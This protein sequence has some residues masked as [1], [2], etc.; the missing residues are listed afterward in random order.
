MISLAEAFRL[1]GIKEEPVYLRCQNEST[2][3]WNNGHYFWSAKIRNKFDMRKIK[4][5]RIDLAFERFGHDFLGWQFIVK[6]V[7]P[8]ELYKAENEE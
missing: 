3:I 8:E 4:V 1:C 6:G 2:N 5:V 7:T